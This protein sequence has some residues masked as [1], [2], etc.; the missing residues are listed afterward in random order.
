MRPPAE[1]NRKPRRFPR[2]QMPEVRLVEDP[3]EARRRERLK[4]LRTRDRIVWPAAA[5]V[6]SFLGDLVF[7]F[8]FRGL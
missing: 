2:T 3:E 7:E 8:L 6:I 4:K 1:R 5:D